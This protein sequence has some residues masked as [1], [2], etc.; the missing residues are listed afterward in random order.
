MDTRNNQIAQDG[1]EIDY[2]TP[3]YGRSAFVN[4][5][6]SSR[7]NDEPMDPR[8]ARRLIE[9][10]LD[11]D[12]RN[13]ADLGSYIC[14]YM[15]PECDALIHR[16]I[17]KVYIDKSEYP[18]MTVMGE[19]V[20]KIIHS[21]FN[22]TN[23]ESEH[24]SNQVLGT[25]T[26]GSSEAIM[27]G[28]MAHRRNWDHAW[29]SRRNLRFTVGEVQQ[30][31]YYSYDKPF[32]LYARDVHTC[33]NKYSNYFNTPALVINL[34]DKRWT[35]QPKDISEMLKMRVKDLIESQSQKHIGMKKVLSDN[36]IYCNKEYMDAASGREKEILTSIYDNKMLSELICCIGAVVGTTFTGEADDVYNIAE[37]IKIGEAAAAGTPN[38][39]FDEGKIKLDIPMH[40]DAASGGFL[41]P[42][43]DPEFAWDF[44]VSKVKSIN[45]SN[46]KFGM[47]YPGCG[48]V[49]FSDWNVVPEEL[50]N[51]ITYLG[52][53]FTDYNVNFS[54]GSSMVIASYYNL[55]RFGRRGYESVN[56]QCIANARYLESKLK[57]SKVIS[58]RLEL[59]NDPKK[60]TMV[61][62]KLNQSAGQNWNLTDLSNE[63]LKQGW[64][65][66][67]YKLPYTN[68][69]IPDG[70][71]VMR[72]VCRQDISHD[73]ID[74]LVKDIEDG[75]KYLDSKTPEEYSFVS[76]EAESKMFRGV[77]EC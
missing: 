25:P 50:I 28:L 63:L 43:S 17:G 54:R 32:L 74:F 60:F 31:P 29:E 46:H 45:V 7:M 67:A 41:V 4:P 35:L 77:L 69:E 2:L 47:V 12:A 58:G 66:P 13:S 27:L 3:T 8:E 9:D 57:E 21:F 5:A 18:A 51:S 70:I 75:F 6:P 68:N 39:Y 56:K 36:L 71:E 52:A 22:G 26:I 44:R 10:E 40:V 16:A 76:K 11:Y 24:K 73:K 53:A 15:D 72:V 49:V 1:A 59:I 19:R 38:N 33:W 65:L 61:V 42:F 55:I 48:T 14:D 23:A 34:S 64:R 30:V 62:F 20:V 37:E